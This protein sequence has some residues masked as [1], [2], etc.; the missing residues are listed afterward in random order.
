MNIFFSEDSDEVLELFS[1]DMEESDEHLSGLVHIES[2]SEIRILCRDTDRA[3]A[4]V[5]DSVLLTS[6]TDHRDGRD[7]DSICSHGNS[8]CYV[9]TRAKSSRDKKCDI[10]TDSSCIEEF[11]SSVDCIWSWDTDI[12]LHMSRSCTSG[13][14]TT[15]DRDK[16]RFTEECDFE[17]SFDMRSDDLDPYRFSA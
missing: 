1:V 14:P 17:I 10:M 4:L 9:S 12:V 11:A 6:Y 8:F 16:I 13:S 15:I 7:S 5:T 3:C 2:C